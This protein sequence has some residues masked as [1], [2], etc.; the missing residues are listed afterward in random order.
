MQL[1]RPLLATLAIAIPA[2]LPV[3]AA[4]TPD[5][6]PVTIHFDAAATGTP[7]NPNI[8]GHFIKGADNYGIFSIPHPDIAAIAEGDGIWNPT[9]RAPYPDALA[10]LQSY[11]PG[12]LR[13]PDGLGIHNHDWK[14]T[15][16]PVE[17][18]DDRKFGLNE[19]MQ[20]ARAVEA[21][22]IIVVSEYIGTPQ[23]AADLV[24]YLN[25]P[26]TPAHPWAMRRAADGHP[27]PYNVLTFEIGNESW[28]DWRKTGKTQVRPPPEVGRYASQIAAAMK[29]VDPRIRC[30]IPLERKDNDRWNR[31]V[32]STITT[33]IDF[34]IIHT[35]PVKYGGGDIT[36]P[37]ENLLLEAMMSAGYATQLDLARIHQEIAAQLGRPLPLAITEYN[38]GPTQQTKNLQRPYRFTLAAALGTGDYLGRL[39]APDSPVESAIYWSWLN[40]A[41]ETVH[42]YASHPWKSRAKLPTPEYRPAHYIFQLWAQNRG[43]TLLPVRT[44]SPRLDFTGI[45]TMKPALGDTPQPEHPLSNTNLLA[46]ARP[47]N[48]SPANIR[49]THAP[50]TANG[51]WTLRYEGHTGGAYPN[52]LIRHLANLPDELRPP[53][54]GLLYKIAFE[55]RW[56][57]DATTL[58][59]PNLGL[60]LMDSRGWNASGSGI[61]IRG[62][63]AARDWTSF[64]GTYQP[65]PDTTAIVILARVEGTTTPLH[66]TLEI[67][68]LTATPWRAATIPARPALTA[69]A[70]RS[71]D[72]S[73]IH[74][75][76]FN[77]TLDRDLPATLTWQNFAAA[78]ATH[79]ELNGTS[80][81]AVNRGEAT[82]GWTRQNA[83]IPLAAPDRLHHT[84]PAHSATGIVLERRIP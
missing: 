52:L 71:A 82:A 65:L 18:R 23:D 76:V 14:K 64:G 53:S 24:E 27:E 60:G 34:A 45:T 81:A 84:F 21:E 83:P 50:D 1:V 11:R 49:I 44:T 37:K 43:H 40:G 17:Q 8:F 42:T 68:N 62:L 28:V 6:T 55:A 22:P 36:G 66:G 31:G 46:L 26:A 9:T 41:F 4:S 56:R 69:Y 57:P 15:I 20:I 7:V 16:G 67:R 63:Q 3:Q 58:S 10:A 32:L 35:Y 13:Y 54:P 80:P 12:T 74:L 33:D 5:R 59:S 39:L 75:T 78:T 73:K 2:Y 61:A 47:I 51:Q 19:F 77:L 38:L 30:G 48:Q 79:T 70:T 25:A 29:A 72:N